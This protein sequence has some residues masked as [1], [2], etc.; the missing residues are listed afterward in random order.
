[1]R[2]TLTIA[3]ILATGLLPLS[4]SACPTAMRIGTYAI[5]NYVGNGSSVVFNLNYQV[6]LANYFFANAQA[7]LPGYSE[8]SPAVTPVR[9]FPAVTDAGVTKAVVANNNAL[10][11]AHNTREW[12][13]FVF[14]AGHGT[15]ATEGVS[16]AALFLGSGGIYGNVSRD[17]LKMGGLSSIKHNR[18]LMVHSCA[19]FPHP[20]TISTSPKDMWKKSF[21]GLRAMLG[22]E[23]KIWDNSDG[24]NLFHAFW[25][26]WTW[27]HMPLWDAFYNAE[28]NYGYSAVGGT[29]VHPGC[30]SG[31]NTSGTTDFCTQNFSNSNLSPADQVGNAGVYHQQVAGSSIHYP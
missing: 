7:I 24:N 27:G 18:W 30:L 4:P 10:T 9:E 19:I 17:D 3:T 11:A 28:L 23:S 8:C 20:P 2:S 13:D 31:I 12:A 25:Y 14:F 29:G 1:M 5:N 6:D 15:P 21:T 26:N 16:P 22:F